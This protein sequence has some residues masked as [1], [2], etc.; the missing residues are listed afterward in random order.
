MPR[1]ISIRPGFTM[2]EIMAT[3][4]LL[5]IFFEASVKVFNSTVLLSSASQDLCDHTSQIDSAMHQL[6]T[7][8]WNCAAIT[9]ADPKSIDVVSAGGAKTS[10]QF[11]GK[12]HLSRTDADGQSARW[13]TGGIELAFSS[14]KV[15][16]TISD[17]TASPMR[18]TSQILLARTEAP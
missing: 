17:G 12:N 2:I 16:L 14:D 5:G 4:I 15:S 8:V 18:M 3:L 13:D 9:V 10:W 1:S 7:D 6:R 11:D